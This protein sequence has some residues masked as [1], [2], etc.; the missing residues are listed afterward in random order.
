[1]GNN[2]AIS[3]PDEW[4]KR[5]QTIHQHHKLITYGGMLTRPDC[6]VDELREKYGFELPEKYM[7][8]AQI[9]PHQ[10]LGRQIQSESGQALH[11][12]LTDVLEQL[13]ARGVNDSKLRLMLKDF[14]KAE[15]DRFLLSMAAGFI[16]GRVES[17]IYLNVESLN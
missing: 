14:D 1:M 4:E 8:L 11:Q 3:I 7:Q 6:T 5:M 12:A 15:K 9:T 2:I 16:A 13:E 17:T 10:E